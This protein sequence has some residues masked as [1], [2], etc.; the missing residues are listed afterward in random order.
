MPMPTIVTILEQTAQ[1]NLFDILLYG[2]CFQNCSHGNCFQFL[3]VY[4]RISDSYTSGLSTMPAFNVHLGQNFLRNRVKFLHR[5]REI[6]RS[7]PLRNHQ[8]LLLMT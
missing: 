2:N 6:G 4:E 5:P 3:R 1:V 7:Y 8:D